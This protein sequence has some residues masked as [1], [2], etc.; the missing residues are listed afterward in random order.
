MK[1]RKISCKKQKP[2]MTKNNG[3]VDTSME[4][5]GRSGGI[6]DTK[7]VPIRHGQNNDY[8]K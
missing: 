4:S 8:G 2:N 7:S 1:K 5:A 3:E 6:S